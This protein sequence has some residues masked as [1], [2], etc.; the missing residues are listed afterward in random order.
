MDNNTMGGRIRFLRQSRGLSQEKLGRELGLTGAA[1]SAWESGG[2][3]DM[4]IENFLRLCHMFQ[5]SHHWLAFGEGG[6][7]WDEADKAAAKR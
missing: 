2:T 1:I 5:C 7:P 3:K 4:K 6:P